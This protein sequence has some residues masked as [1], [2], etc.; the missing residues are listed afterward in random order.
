MDA[1]RAKE[2]VAMSVTTVFR[3]FHEDAFR[4]WRRDPEHFDEKDHPDCESIQLGVESL[5]VAD[6]VARATNE[7]TRSASGKFL[8]DMISGTVGT[9]VY[10]DG[11]DPSV[12]AR[13]TVAR[14]SR[15]M[16][17]IREA[18]LR[19][20]YDL[21]RLKAEIGE[22]EDWLWDAFGSTVL[23]DYLIPMFEK[24]RNLF[25]RAAERRQKLVVSWF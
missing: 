17:R 20:V 3:C 23:E 24:I 7:R 22:I 14:A 6:L 11:H 13:S 12:I 19:A 16:N 9:S 10:R 15:M 2:S 21:N 5:A 18:D 1:T 4:D 25:Q 8:S